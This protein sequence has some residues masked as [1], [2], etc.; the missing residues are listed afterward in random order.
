MV[1]HAG[2]ADEH[3]FWLGVNLG[4]SLA[5]LTDSGSVDDR[6]QLLD[7]VCHQAV[8]EVHIA[9]SEVGKVHVLVNGSLLRVEHL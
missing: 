5:S 9:C 7:V 4:P 6:G 3:T 8:E 1:L 2:K